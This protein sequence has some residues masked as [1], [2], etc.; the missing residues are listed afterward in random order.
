[1]T[2][3]LP[4]QGTLGHSCFGCA[5]DNPVGLGLHFRAEGD[6]LV[7]DLHVDRRYESYPGVVHGGIV[8][9][10]CDETMGNLA[11]LRHGRAVVTT[12][13]RTRHVGV[14]ATGGRYRC[15]ASLAGEPPTLSARAEVLDADGAVVATATA[16]YRVPTAD[17]GG[18]R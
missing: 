8:A 3:A 4:W 17:P 15:R 16:G 9:L 13:L 1:M 14:V 2:V 11:V 7:T 12:S 18:P 5:P 10:V 6:D